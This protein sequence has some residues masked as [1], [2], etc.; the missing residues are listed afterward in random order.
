MT[1]K[2]IYLFKAA[3]RSHPG[4]RR[5]I[6]ASSPRQPSSCGLVL[7]T[8]KTHKDEMKISE[9]IPLEREGQPAKRK[10]GAMP[11]TVPGAIAARDLKARS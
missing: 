11:G 8:Q 4:E 10:S 9:K 7:V 3:R 1:R 5:L 6:I 2:P